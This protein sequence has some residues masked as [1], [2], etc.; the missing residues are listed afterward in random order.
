LQ[1][2]RVKPIIE[3]LRTL[4]GSAQLVFDVI[5]YPFVLISAP[6]NYFSFI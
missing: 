2:V 3:K 1:S 6:T 5:Q 4:G